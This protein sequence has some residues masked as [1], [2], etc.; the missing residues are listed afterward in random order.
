MTRKT[1]L[2]ASSL[3]KTFNLPESFTVFE[4]VSLE[5]LEGSSTAIIGKSGEGKSTL[6]NIL[7]TLEKPTQGQL[8]IDGFDT[9][10]VN[11]DSLRNRS[12]GFIFQNYHLLEDI[13][14]LENVLI[15]ASIARLNTKKGSEAYSKAL[16]L[17][18]RVGLLHR[19]DFLAS[20][21]SGGEKQRV[22]IARA[23]M[24]SPKILLADELTG[25]LDR[26]T[27]YG[28]HEL[29]FSTDLTRG[30]AKI[31]VTHDME[32]ASLC[33]TIYCLEDGNLKL[34]QTNHPS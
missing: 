7:G 3:S 16:Y 29:L 18:E 2:K 13:S 11:T 10:T 33:D 24:N 9:S 5:I 12:L 25:N 20:Q 23:L 21:L 32:L 15:P 17:L 30:V 19:K 14:V 27:S 26:K 1:L 6:L 22:A 31:I 8:W 34:L 4:G 28:I